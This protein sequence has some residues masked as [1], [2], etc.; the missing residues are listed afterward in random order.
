MIA[1]TTIKVD[2]TTKE[3]LNHLKGDGESFNDVVNRLIDENQPE[4][5][6]E[7]LTMIRSVKVPKGTVPKGIERYILEIHEL[8]YARDLCSSIVA[9][10]AI[11]TE[12]KRKVRWVLRYLKVDVSSEVSLEGAYNVALYEHIW[13]G[14]PQEYME[15]VADI[16]EV[17]K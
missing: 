7:P 1:D 4:T 10:K 12:I 2:R 8:I 9:K 11:D 16:T 14:K 6:Y 17:K 15:G 5:D 3:R 13:A